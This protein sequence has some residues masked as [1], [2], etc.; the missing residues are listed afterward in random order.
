MILCFS[1]QPSDF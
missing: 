1:D